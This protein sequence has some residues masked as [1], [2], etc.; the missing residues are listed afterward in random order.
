MLVCGSVDGQHKRIFQRIAN[1][2]SK[3]GPFDFMLCC[4]SFPGRDTSGEWHHFLSGS[5]AVP[6]PVYVLGGVGSGGGDAGGELCPNVVALGRRGVFT[7]CGGLRVAYLAPAI[8]IPVSQDDVCALES[9]VTST[10]AAGV[11]ILITSCWP[12][13][14]T[15]LAANP[16]GVFS[17][18]TGSPLVSRLLFSLRP[19]YVFTGGLQIHYER[20]PYRNHVVL[21]QAQCHVTRFISLAKALNSLKKKWLY[22]FSL[23]PMDLMDRVELIQQPADTTGSPFSAAEMAALLAPPDAPSQYF[24]STD[25]RRAGDDKRSQQQPR[26]RKRLNDDGRQQQPCWFCLASPK[27]EKHLVVHVGEMCYLALAKGGLV[28]DHALILPIDHVPCLAISSDQ[29]H[30]EVA[31]Y[32]RRLAEMYRREGQALVVYERNYRQSHFQ[33]Q[34]VPVPCAL[35]E[36]FSLLRHV[37]QQCAAAGVSLHELP[38]LAEL[39]QVARDGSPYFYVG[40]PDGRRLYHQIASGG[41]SGGAAGGVGE[42]PLNLGRAML[43]SPALLNMPDRAE[44]TRC[45]LDTAHETELTRQFKERFK[46]IQ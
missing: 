11:D 30:N 5:I 29:L 39:R 46:Q 35:A 26:K 21:Q 42:F 41:G 20:L 15:R 8:G 3:S 27:V 2:N 14:V 44:W 25:R 28:P 12:R 13:G 19:R 1:I 7:T 6:L 33:M 40:L 43:A 16:D 9:T 22:A 10:G 4:G 32:Q 24:Y 37:Q 36:P 31:N 38:R 45:V 18:E 34:C 17:E 23:T